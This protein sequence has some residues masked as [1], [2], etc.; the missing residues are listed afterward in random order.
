MWNFYLAIFYREA[1]PEGAGINFKEITISLR[2]EG[3]TEPN[4]GAGAP[5]TCASEHVVI[6]PAG[7]PLRAA[8]F[9]GSVGGIY[10]PAEPKKEGVD[11][12]RSAQGA[13]AVR[14]QGEGRMRGHRQEQ[15]HRMNSRG[16]S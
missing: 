11:D 14:R 7:R 6:S 3:N 5:D 16:A 1:R 10:W 13:K 8:C 9:L 4:S 12:T 15:R 2:N